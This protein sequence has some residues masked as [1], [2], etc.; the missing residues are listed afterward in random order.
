MLK[1]F[2]K[3][4]TYIVAL[5]I[6]SISGSI[7]IN[8]ALAAWSEPSASPPDG[9]DIDLV[10]TGLTV[11]ATASVDGIAKV[12][13]A[14]AQEGVRIISSNYSPFIIRNT[15]NNADLL[16]I[17]ESGELVLNNTAAKGSCAAGN[18]GAMVFDTVEDKPYVCASTGWKPL[19]SDYDKDGIVDWNDQ[20]DTNASLKH[21]NLVPGNVA[22]GV[23]IFGVVGTYAGAE[24][25]LTYSGATH[26]EDECTSLGGMILN[27]G[28]GTFC[29]I[30]GANCPVG[31]TQAGNYQ[32]YNP[33][34][35]GGDDCS[36]SFTMSSGP[37]IF[38]GQSAIIKSRTQFPFGP[39]SFY[40]G[41]GCSQTT[42]TVFGNNTNCSP[43]AMAEYYGTIE[44]SENT[45]TNRVEIGCK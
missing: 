42:W 21:V 39:P 30:I 13:P 40:C 38:T 35:W 28:D 37:S 22:N 17:N 41:G 18:K 24:E 44:I 23:N 6:V 8:S 7:L 5:T 32:R 20:D 1:K 19:D 14:A 9:N 45:S 25:S 15:A 3:S 10:V 27:Y 36:N 16:R 2:L 43:S 31:W 11:G 4:T 12:A 29:K 34:T 33:S 26:L